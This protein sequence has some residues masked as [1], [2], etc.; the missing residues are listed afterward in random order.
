MNVGRIGDVLCLHYLGIQLRY[1]C[2]HVAL[3][4]LGMEPRFSFCKRDPPFDP[5]RPAK[6]SSN[7]FQLESWAFR[8]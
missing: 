8:I 3:F 7:T 6:N 1:P 4:Q 2:L 5:S